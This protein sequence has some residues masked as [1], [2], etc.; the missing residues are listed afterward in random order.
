MAEDRT[1][2][3]VDTSGF[4]GDPLARMAAMAEARA[5]GHDVLTDPDG[6]V[7]WFL[8]ADDAEA[9]LTSPAIGSAVAM[10]VLELSG[11]HDG[12][13]HDLWSV[14]MF[15]KDG[16]EHQRLRRTVN[17]RLTPR[18]VGEL[19]PDV[20]ADSAEL[21]AAWPD[22]G[23][24]ELW[25]SYAFPLV[26]RTACRLVGVPV[27][28]AEPVGRLALRVVRAFGGLEPDVAANTEAAAAELLAHLDGLV[29]DDRVVPGS[30]LAD[31]LADPRDLTADEVRGL[32][33]NL[34]FGGL[35]ATAKAIPTGVLELLTHGGAWA[36]LAADP[37]SVAPGAVAELLRFL[38]PAAGVLRFAGEATECR[39]VAIPAGQVVGLNL[40]GVCRDPAHTAD[41][42]RLEVT[43]EPGHAYAFG[44]G[45]HYC[46][47]ASLARL[48]LTVAFTDLAAT[49][50]G[51]RLATPADEVL[52][53]E[54]PFRGVVHLSLQLA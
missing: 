53:T 5:A 44:A 52:W 47:G 4:E 30:V 39:G 19:R 22:T 23:T 42:D 35:D 43:R 50:P 10:A 8:A 26:A 2:H 24:V 29:A 54:D 18:A 9:L 37:A 25:D 45:P 40:D 16:E 20:E 27:E 3:V 15:G 51:L 36:A 46:L 32:A 41:P 31:L 14:L 12:P 7:L 33:A 21:L 6:V 1:P 28:D 13:L 17:R 48:V 34:L 11:V 38:P 49:H